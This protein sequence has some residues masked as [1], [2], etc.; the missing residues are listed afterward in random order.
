MKV[1]RLASIKS[2]TIVCLKLIASVIIEEGSSEMQRGQNPPGSRLE[3][4]CMRTLKSSKENVI[5]SV[6]EKTWLH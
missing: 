3:K 2:I 5:F 4:P 1:L 6:Y